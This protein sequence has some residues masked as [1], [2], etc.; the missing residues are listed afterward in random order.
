MS[1]LTVPIVR[2]SHITAGIYFIFLKKHPG[3]NL[4]IFQY[5]IWASVKRSEKEL[6]SKTK[7]SIFASELL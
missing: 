5:R 4:K 3:P 2:N 6:A 1:L 7:L